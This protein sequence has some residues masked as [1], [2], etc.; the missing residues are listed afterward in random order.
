MKKVNLLQ[1]LQY[2]ARLV[3][4]GLIHLVEAGRVDPGVVPGHRVVRL[5][6]TAALGQTGPVSPV[7]RGW[8]GRQGGRDVRHDGNLNMVRGITT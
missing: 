2:P 7:S 1:G 4:R 5:R 8:Q 3:G 6:W